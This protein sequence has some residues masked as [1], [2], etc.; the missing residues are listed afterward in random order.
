MTELATFSEFETVKYEKS[1]NLNQ[2]YDFISALF[3]C[4]QDYHCILRKARY[5]PASALPLPSLFK[6]LSRFKEKTSDLRYL[7][8]RLVL[9]L[10]HCRRAAQRIDIPE[11]DVG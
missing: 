6:L 4:G 8:L 7:K 11:P 10:T 9:S 5:E 1:C 3:L 2:D